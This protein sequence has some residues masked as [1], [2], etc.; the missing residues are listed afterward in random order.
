MQCYLVEQNPIIWKSA[1]HSDVVQ[2]R[3]NEYFGWQFFMLAEAEKEF[4]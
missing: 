4:S 2:T 3:F 1:I